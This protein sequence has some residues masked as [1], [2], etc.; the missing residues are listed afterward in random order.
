M[1]IYITNSQFYFTNLDN[2][3]AKAKDIIRN[4]YTTCQLA[5]TEEWIVTQGKKNGYF[6]QDT[7]KPT[8]PVIIKTVETED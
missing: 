5:D 1:K 8:I 2:A 4:K 3:I 7:N 6:V